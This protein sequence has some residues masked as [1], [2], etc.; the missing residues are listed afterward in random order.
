MRL[1]TDFNNIDTDADAL[2]DGYEVFTLG[3]NPLETDS[4]N[5]G[6]SDSDEDF[7][8]DGL[9]NL[10]EQQLVTDPRLND[11][12]ADKLS[13]GDEINEYHTDPLLYD[14]DGDTIGDGD[15]I[16]LGLNPLASSTNG[17][18]DN[19]YMIEQTASQEAL[20]YVN[21]EENAYELSIDMTASGNAADNIIVS[22]SQYTNSLASNDAIV[23]QTISVDYYSG[24]I[25]K[26][27]LSFKVDAQVIQ[28]ATEKGL[29]NS[30]AQG[31]EKFYVFNFNEDL[32]MLIPVPTTYDQINRTL[33][34]DFIGNGTYCVM[35]VEKWLVDIGALENSTSNVND[36]NSTYS[37]LATNK[38]FS[39][40]L[41]SPMTFS[42]NESIRPLSSNGQ[43]KVDLV[44]V[45][46]TGYTM[47]PVLESVKKGIKAIV[48]ILIEDNIDV[49]VCIIDVKDVNQIN[50]PQ[51]IQI[52]GTPAPQAEGN[53]AL[54]FTNDIGHLET[55]VDDLAAEGG[56]DYYTLGTQMAGVAYTTTLPYRQGA[57]KFVLLLTDKCTGID[58]Y[59]GY[60]TIFELLD[61]LKA[62]N[63]SFSASSMNRV[64]EG[65]IPD[66]TVQNYRRYI[67]RGNGIFVPLRNF[68]FDVEIFTDFVVTNL[69][70]QK[71]FK[72]LGNVD[73]EEI[74]L[75]AP[76]VKGG[77][78][79]SD[80][81]SLTDSEEVDWS[82]DRISYTSTGYELPTLQ[83]LWFDIDRS[84]DY[85]ME[86]F[87]FSAEFSQ[88]KVLPLLSHPLQ[89]DSDNDGLTDYEDTM[90]FR[91]DYKVVWS[92]VSN[93]E[94]I[95]YFGQLKYSEDSLRLIDYTIATKQY[96][97]KAYIDGEWEIVDEQVEFQNIDIGQEVGSSVIEANITEEGKI[98]ISHPDQDIIFNLDPFRN[99]ASQ[100]I[101]QGIED[102]DYR[103][104]GIQMGIIDSCLMPYD[105]GLELW[106]GPGTSEPVNFTVIPSSSKIKMCVLSLLGYEE[107][108]LQ[109]NET[110][111]MAKIQTEE[112][113]SIVSLVGIIGGVAKLIEGGIKIVGGTY[114]TS[115]TGGA[116]IPIAID[117]IGDVA[118][119]VAGT[120]IAYSIGTNSTNQ[121]NKDK[122]TL[123]K[124][125]GKSFGES[126]EVAK[127][128]DKMPELT[129][130]N[131]EK[132]LSVVQ[133]AD[134]NKIVNELYREGA[135]VGDGGTA[136]K[137]VEEFNN[138]S[139]RHLQK[140]IERLG[141]LNDLADTGRLGLNDMDILDALRTDLEYAINLFQK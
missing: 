122:E 97:V 128:L 5:N 110:Y 81:D 62:K 21:T 95:Y 53:R 123:K 67:N 17:V 36:S 9:D 136:A 133:D 82:Y 56:Y 10:Q 77:Q 99:F 102:N 8:E 121:S 118:L 83:N 63:I 139:S 24:K 124:L 127:L 70:E 46:D 135:I 104:L 61:D 41:M 6:I 7:D 34:T 20:E 51:V 55:I 11:T 86:D 68:D 39:T 32:N 54:S 18:P 74:T 134:L 131:R 85:D 129:G 138:G 106:G 112:I 109:E 115:G 88:I 14:T 76:L 79:D 87:P 130:T 101:E 43:K 89:E 26:G 80:E 105:M 103:R 44:F 29:I 47:K 2:P 132:L 57:N 25:E 84:Y 12:D 22:T 1:G 16:K 92:K 78:T 4:D 65:S 111:L 93:E 30:E 27:T 119:G 141:N 120:K 3:T 91:N 107:T 19:E 108:D 52:N 49:E 59:H 73:L 71:E 37:L 33:V 64:L 28:D 117:G 42:A 31:I 100:M 90:P 69:I 140:A 50:S 40:E 35:N 58:N 75:D 125:K 66:N 113:V 60:S 94:H 116:S 98:Q 126:S 13:D 15:E 45:I 114:F 38:Q 23:G 96:I 48:N 72:I 137:L